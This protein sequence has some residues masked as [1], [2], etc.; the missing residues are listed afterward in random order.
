[1]VQVSDGRGGTN[2]QS[3]S[4]KVRFNTGPSIKS[5]PSRT[6]IVGSSYSYSVNAEDPEGGTLTYTLVNAPVGM[7]IDPNTGLITWSPLSADAG[8]YKITVMVTD[9][10]GVTT[11]QN[12]NLT[13]LAV[14]AIPQI[15]TFVTGPDDSGVFT[16]QYQ[17]SNGI[18]APAAIY[19]IFM[20]LTAPI[21]NITVPNG[22]DY[23]TDKIRFVHI[24]ST[25][26]QFDVPAGSVLSGFAVTGTTGPNDVDSHILN[27]N[28]NLFSFTIKGP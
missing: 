24:F 27:A 3:F 21:L 7:T 26:S 5:V 23:I 28:G 2:T 15:D 10:R 19:D 14:N 6:T 1:M 8:I 22:W 20:P 4:I 25:H 16:Y 12:Y 17:I 9:E 18:D 13:V 11:S